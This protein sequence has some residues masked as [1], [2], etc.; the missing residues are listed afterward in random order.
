MAWLAGFPQAGQGVDL[1]LCV[2]ADETTE[3]WIR[4]FGG[5]ELRTVQ[6]SAGTLMVESSGPVRVRFRVTA[7]AAGLRF[8]SRGAR[9]WFVPIPLRIEAREW[10]DDTSWQ[11]EVKVTGVGSY[12]GR[13]VRA[14]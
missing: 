1:R 12:S 4:N 2:V 5:K 7:D 3:T 14:V 10:G 9:F 6:R 13:M 11:F 8:E